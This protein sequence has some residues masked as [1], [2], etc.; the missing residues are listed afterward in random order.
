MKPFDIELAKAGNPVCT[1]DGRSARIICFDKKCTTLDFNIVALVDWKDNE[2]V[3]EVIVYNNEGR[4]N[5][6]NT[7]NCSDLFM[8]P[9]KK[10]GWVNICPGGSYGAV[11]SNAY[12]TKEDAIANKR[13]DCVDT[14]K[15]EWEEY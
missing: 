6:T 15:I 3:E 9:I 12:A 10:S 13:N 7:D 5:L 2:N 11:V 14:I 1:R 8:A 4:V